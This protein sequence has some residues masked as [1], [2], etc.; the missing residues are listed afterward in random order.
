VLY[1]RSGYPVDQEASDSRDV[2]LDDPQRADAVDPHHGGGGITD[3]AACAA[4]IGGCNDG[5][6]VTDMY[7]APEHVPR[8]GA[9]DQGGGNIVEKARHHEYNRKQ[10]QAAAPSKLEERCGRGTALLLP[11]SRR[12]S[13]WRCRCLFS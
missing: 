12:V 2:G 3:N 8:H 6:K 9:T 5:G 11:L 4:R 7:F 1:Q 13:D 10:D